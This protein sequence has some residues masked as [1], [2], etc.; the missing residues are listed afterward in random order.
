MIA[1][2][3]VGPLEAFAVEDERPIRIGLA[4]VTMKFR[5]WCGSSSRMWSFTRAIREVVLAKEA[6]RTWHI[7][8][9]LW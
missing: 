5:S 4:V 8:G 1:L 6:S 2:V 9:G 7:G 3:G